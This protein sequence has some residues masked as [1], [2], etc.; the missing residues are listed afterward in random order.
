MSRLNSTKF[1]VSTALRF[2]EILG[3]GKIYLD[4][5]VE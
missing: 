4:D 2:R 5:C 3:T 1:E